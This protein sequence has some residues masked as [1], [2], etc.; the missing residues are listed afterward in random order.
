MYAVCSAPLLRAGRH[1]SVCTEVL[2]VVAAVSPGAYP[3]CSR[4][5][6]VGVSV[7]CKIPCDFI[8]QQLHFHKE[9]QQ[10]AGALEMWSIW[11]TELSRLAYEW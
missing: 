5:L 1:S 4:V 10:S 7:Y 3:L 8:A 6:Q 9:Q 11:R 2:H